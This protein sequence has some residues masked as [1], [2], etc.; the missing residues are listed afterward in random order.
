MIKVVAI[1]DVVGKVGRQSL[2]KALP[3]IR[4]K[5]QPDI[6]VVNGENAAGGFGIT[7]KILQQFLEKLEIDCV[8]TGNH[9]HDKRDIFKLLDSSERLVVPA[10]MFNVEKLE[11]GFKILQTKTGVSF[12]VVN[13]VGNAFMHTDNRNLFLCL[14]QIF[15]QIPSNVKIRIVDVHA[16][17]TSEK[18]GVG[19]YLSGTA[20][21]VFGT[22]SH[23]PTADER[24]LGEHTG[25]ITDLGM[26]GAYDSVIGMK[27]DAAISRMKDG[28][29]KRFEPASKNPWV[30]FIIAEIDE[31]NGA[32]QKIVRNR[33]ETEELNPD[34]VST[35]HGDQRF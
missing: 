26:T 32:C 27:A 29:R 1:G 24:I 11:Y 20:S 5:Y 30:P 7:P 19:C 15:K 25:F 8:T 9:W 21:L 12:A 13:I 3:L 35:Y 22:H 17:A 16:E 6:I 34:R 31:A 4:D 14:D 23:V 10:N 28:E 2:V 18:Q 33:W